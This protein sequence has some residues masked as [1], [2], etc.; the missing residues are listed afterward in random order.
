M[1]ANYASRPRRDSIISSSWKP[2]PQ[3]PRPTPCVIGWRPILNESRAVPFPRVKA[4][5]IFNPTA[6]GNKARRFRKQLDLIGSQAALKQTMTAG[7]ARRLAMGAV[8]EGFDTIVA[9]G[10]D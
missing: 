3:I 7:E 6:R 1:P 4:C 5:V 9:A 8:T 2:I 10:G